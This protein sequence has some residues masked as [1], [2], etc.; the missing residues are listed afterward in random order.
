KAEVPSQVLANGVQNFRSRLT[1]GGGLQ[2]DS[3]DGVPGGAAAFPRLSLGD[4]PDAVD[5]K[6][7]VLGL[8]RAE[9]D[10]EGEFTPVLAPAD[11]IRSILRR[12]GTGA[13]ANIDQLV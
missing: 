8:Q 5:D 3:P 13:D 1:E 12:V 10:F 7:S 6:E 4:V 11:R 2:E 9:A